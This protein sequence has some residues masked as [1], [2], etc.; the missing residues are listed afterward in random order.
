M[1]AVPRQA[2]GVHRPRQQGTLGRVALQIWASEGRGAP[3]G[4]GRMWKGRNSHSTPAERGQR[5]V[6]HRITVRQ[7]PRAVT[8]I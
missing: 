2:P 8:K 1:L 4:C 7:G 3:G 5:G 6:S